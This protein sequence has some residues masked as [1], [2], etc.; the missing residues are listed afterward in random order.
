MSQLK[1]TGFRDVTGLALSLMKVQTLTKGCYEKR[2]KTL[3]SV[4]H[5]R[6][7]ELFLFVLQY[8]GVRS[9]WT[10]GQ[11]L[12]RQSVI[13]MISDLT[14]DGSTISNLK[15]ILAPPGTDPSS[16]WDDDT[17]TVK[18]IHELEYFRPSARLLTSNQ[19]SVAGTNI[20]TQSQNEDDDGL[21]HD[22]EAIRALL[23]SDP[24][25][26]ITWWFL[27]CMVQTSRH[28]E[29]LSAMISRQ[30]QRNLP[31]T[32]PWCPNIM[33]DCVQM[34]WLT[35]YFVNSHLRQMPTLLENR[36]EREEAKSIVKGVFHSM[37]PYML[38]ELVEKHGMNNKATEGF[39]GIIKRFPSNSQF[40]RVK[41]FG[42]A[43]LAMYPR[44]K[45]PSIIGGT[46]FYD[47]VVN[48]MMKRFLHN[49]IEVT[50]A[51]KVG[52]S[53][54][55][56]TRDASAVLQEMENG[57][58][59]LPNLLDEMYQEILKE[60]PAS[61]DRQRKGITD[62]QKTSSKKARKSN[63]TND[64][65]TGEKASHTSSA[66]RGGEDVMSL[67]DAQ[68]S[69]G[70]MVK[71]IHSY[72]D[73]LNENGVRYSPRTVLLQIAKAT[74]YEGIE[75]L[76][77]TFSDWGMHSQSDDEAASDN[78]MH[79]E[80]VAWAEAARG[81][82]QPMR[83][84]S[85]EGQSSSD[86]EDHANK[87]NVELKRQ[88]ERERDDSEDESTEETRGVARKLLKRGNYRWVESHSDTSSDT[89]E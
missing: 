4:L 10:S 41:V 7:P 69:S 55:E 5:Q 43:S 44:S 32:L 52:K 59:P 87:R 57:K 54:D 67:P 48:P 51:E 46:D 56:N 75:A 42:I 61:V 79:Q 27:D 80:Q 84:Q 86:D 21:E 53:P 49:V 40:N 88:R 2:S 24:W 33:Y 23:F 25:L 81:G 66:D 1:G 20:P 72:L 60:L 36:L 31:G 65:R 14:E 26:K 83:D 13:D 19:A 71:K 62:G 28:A 11:R 6:R 8:F 39:R 29:K 58:S 50:G 34:F 76:E 35:S 68:D 82:Q 37:L 22:K 16:E 63:V 45:M 3:M 12:S 70:E 18:P 64:T 47:K 73:M 15:L 78:E 89:S 85:G 77:S 30:Y 74:G 17:K 9:T 38:F